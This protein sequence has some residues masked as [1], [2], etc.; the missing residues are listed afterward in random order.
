MEESDCRWNAVEKTHWEKSNWPQTY[1]PS[2]IP[3]VMNKNNVSLGTDRLAVERFKRTTRMGRLPLQA[4]SR[5]ANTR[6][7]L[8]Q[9]TVP[10]HSERY[11]TN[12]KQLALRPAHAPANQLPIGELERRLLPA[13]R[14]QTDCLRFERQY[15]QDLGSAKPPMCKGLLQDSTPVYI[16]ESWK[17]L[18]WFCCYS[19]SYRAYWFSTL[20]TVW[21]TRDN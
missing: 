16:S 8:L 1:N 20:F 13:V 3:W 17:W 4:S 9:K 5:R 18:M 14:R 11:W 19:G 2:P 6:P 12:R 10:A 21:W 15:N 7:F